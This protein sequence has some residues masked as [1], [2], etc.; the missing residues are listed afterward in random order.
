[1]V[2]C[3]IILCSILRTPPYRG[4][5]AALVTRVVDPVSQGLHPTARVVRLHALQVQAPQ[6]WSHPPAPGMGRWRAQNRVGLA[7]HSCSAH[8]ETDPNGAEA[9]RAT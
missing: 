3:S 6:T 2:L 4:S 1:M 9:R 5:F 8:P 7:T